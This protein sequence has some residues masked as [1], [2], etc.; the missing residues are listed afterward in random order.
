MG[1]Y[2]GSPNKEK[3]SREEKKDGLHYGATGMQGWRNT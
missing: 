2:L 3:D 1:P